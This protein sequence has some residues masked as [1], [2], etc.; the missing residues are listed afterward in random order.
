E[1]YNGNNLKWR[2]ERAHEMNASVDVEA[3]LE[4]SRGAAW[5]ALIDGT[6]LYVNS[7]G[8]WREKA[9]TQTCMTYNV[10]HTV[11]FLQQKFPSAV[12]HP[13]VNSTMHHCCI[14]RRKP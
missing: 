1:T 5:C 14:L 12:I 3:L 2:L 4:Q 7:N 10:F 13:P 8:D 11:E 9:K 6:D